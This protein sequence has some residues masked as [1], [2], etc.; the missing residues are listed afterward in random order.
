MRLSARYVQV[1][2]ACA[3]LGVLAGQSLFSESQRQDLPPSGASASRT[4]DGGVRAGESRP[5]FVKPADELATTGEMAGSSRKSRLPALAELAA[6][7][8]S[9]PGDLPEGVTLS[10]FVVKW[11]SAL[12]PTPAVVAACR[13][14]THAEYA[15]VG[16][17]IADPAVDERLAPYL[18]AKHAP[19]H[20]DTW[21]QAAVTEDGWTHSATTWPN[22]NS[23]HRA[24]VDDVFLM[25]VIGAGGR[26]AQILLNEEAHSLQEFGNVDSLT[27]Y[28]ELREFAAYLRSIKGTVEVGKI[29]KGP[30]GDEVDMVL[31][32]ELDVRSGGLRKHLP[33]DLVL[34][35]NGVA[36]WLG[37]T[38]LLDRACMPRHVVLFGHAGRLR[39]EIT[40]SSYQELAPRVHLPLVVQRTTFLPDGKTPV[41]HVRC[42]S[43]VDRRAQGAALPFRWARGLR[44]YGR[45]G[46]RL[47]SRSLKF[48]SPMEL[49]KVIRAEVDG[50]GPPRI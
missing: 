37:V 42:S 40:C 36:G 4:D 3:I 8:W 27:L 26:S 11:R 19:L 17:T 46:S 2:V 45:V 7:T 39:M 9:A 49:T 16:V 29:R 38:V 18:T 22:G 21:K 41:L 47:I 32:L 25:Q 44:L 6:D 1:A 48:M 20:T 13:R 10:S 12:P 50:A 31:P 34:D 28:G 14:G 23:V 5:G 35:A 15:H 33:P 24:Q 43:R 30:D